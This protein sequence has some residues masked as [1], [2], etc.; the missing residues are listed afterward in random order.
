[1][2]EQPIPISEDDLRELFALFTSCTEHERKQVY[3]SRSSHYFLNQNISEEH[4]LTEEKRE[5]A[6]DAWRSVLYFLHKKG[7]SLCKN[8]EDIDLS[9]I[10]EA[11]IP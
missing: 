2:A 1:M 9:F 8:G 11:F 6:L 10:K 7:Y 3:S 4:S 5:Y